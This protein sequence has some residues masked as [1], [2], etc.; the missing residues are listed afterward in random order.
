MAGRLPPLRARRGHSVWA[1]RSLPSSLA[2]VRCCDESRRSRAAPA[3][4]PSG[5]D[6]AA[7]PWVRSWS[8]QEVAHRSGN[9]VPGPLS[10]L[11]V[12]AEESAEVDHEPL[13]HVGVAAVRYEGVVA[14]GQSCGE[15]LV[16][17]SGGGAPP[18]GPAADD[19]ARAFERHRAEWLGRCPR[20]IATRNRVDQ[21]EASR[22]DVPRGKQ[23]DEPTP[24]VTTQGHVHA[25][26]LEA[27]DHLAKMTG[28][29]LCR[30]SRGVHP[31][32]Q[33]RLRELSRR[34]R[35]DVR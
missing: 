1:D 27:A 25:V 20:P 18:V 5:W 22:S 29:L 34:E 8:C 24:G 2:S 30:P 16:V 14:S 12:T 6:S 35:G 33:A 7:R 26:A 32:S 11:A 21:Q 15:H 19:E 31:G 3:N 28:L 4:R 9:G 23:G 13:E 10:V 17:A